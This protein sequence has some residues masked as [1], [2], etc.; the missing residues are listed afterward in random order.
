M[1]FRGEHEHRLLVCIADLVPVRHELIEAAHEPSDLLHGALAHFGDG[2]DPHAVLVE[3]DVLVDELDDLRLLVHDEDWLR[4]D[5]APPAL[6]LGEA[7]LA[8]HLV[9]DPLGFGFPLRLP[10]LLPCRL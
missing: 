6:C 9:L 4:E 10:E 7:S 2:T 5:G 1:I 8:L 3:H